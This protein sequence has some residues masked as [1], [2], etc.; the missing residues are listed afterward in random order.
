M[1]QG[2]SAPFSPCSKASA[3]PT[4]AGGRGRRWRD[5]EGIGPGRRKD[6]AV[7]NA[8][9]RDDRDE[10]SSATIA[11][12]RAGSD[13]EIPIE[14]D[15][16]DGRRL[17]VGERKDHDPRSR[18]R[19]RSG[20]RRRRAA[21]ASPRSSSGVAA[22]VRA[23]RSGDPSLTLSLRRSAMQATVVRGE[24]ERCSRCSHGALRPSVSRPLSA[25]GG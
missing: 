1:G 8:Q 13:A 2:P 16:P 9:G 22:A 15:L 5:A 3:L 4:S 18:C 11:T 24:R 17:V 19:S 12:A 23:G 21:P 20:R 7:A 6:Q 10:L 25:V 14:R